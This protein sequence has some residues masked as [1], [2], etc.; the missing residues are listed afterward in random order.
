M[1]MR[2]S[3]DQTSDW[4]AVADGAGGHRNGSE[5]AARA[6][7]DALDTIPAA[8][9]AAEMLIQV[10][11]RLSAVHETLHEAASRLGEGAMM[12]ATV[13]ALIARDGHFACLWAGDSRAYLGRGGRVEQLTVDH[14]LVQD[15]VDRGSIDAAEAEAIPTRT[16]SRGRSVRPV[17]S[18]CSTSGWARSSR[19][20]ASCCAAMVWSSRC[21]R[22]IC[23]PCCRMVP[24]RTYWSEPR[25]S[26]V[27]RIT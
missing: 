5:T 26:G 27:R 17:S 3:T 2:C 15:L 22:R 10:R 7:V 13:V 11:L 4:R 25:W 8:L 16:S 23:R 14:S 24:R 6:V 1:K 21:R 12:A 20:I 18:W 9:T 19:A